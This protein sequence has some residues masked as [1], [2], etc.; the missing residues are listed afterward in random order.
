MSQVDA[1]TSPPLKRSWTLLR[2]SVIGLLLL[3]TFFVTYVAARSMLF[4]KPKVQASLVGTWLGDHGVIL[5]L[6]ADGTA[7][8]RSLTYLQDGVHYFE[9]SAADG[10]LTAEMLSPTRSFI[11]QVRRLVF[12]ENRFDFDI[13]ELTEAELQMH[14]RSTGKTLRFVPTR[15]RALENAP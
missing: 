2:N 11:R 12:G 6:R 10:V 8:S 7:R 3:L 9:W 13:V 14:D 15:D 4:P 5:D 1:K